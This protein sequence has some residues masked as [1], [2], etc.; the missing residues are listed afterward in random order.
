MTHSFFL[1]KLFKNILKYYI[2]IY[3]KIKNTKNI[4]IKYF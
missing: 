3:I 1:K 2:Y 4:L